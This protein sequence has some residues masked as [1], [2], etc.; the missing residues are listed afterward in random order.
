MA[1]CGHT[2]RL[3][4]ERVQERESEREHRAGTVFFIGIE[5]GL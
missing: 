3:P 4:I 5:G 2:A 1:H